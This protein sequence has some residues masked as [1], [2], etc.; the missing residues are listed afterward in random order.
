MRRDRQLSTLRERVEERRGDMPRF[1]TWDRDDADRAAAALA[2]AE[3]TG[4]KHV[5][6]S[7]ELADDALA[8]ANKLKAELATQRKARKAE[9]RAL[10]KR[11]AKLDEGPEADEVNRQLE[12]LESFDDSELET[13]I[14]DY[15]Y[16]ARE[17]KAGAR[18]AGKHGSLAAQTR[19]AMARGDWKAAEKLRDKADSSGVGED[20]IVEYRVYRARQDD[21][22]FAAEFARREAESEAATRANAPWSHG[23]QYWGSERLPEGLRK[24][25]RAASEALNE[26]RAPHYAEVPAYELRTPDPED[27]PVQLKQERRLRRLEEYASRRGALPGRGLLAADVAPTPRPALREQAA[28]RQ[29][30][31]TERE[32]LDVYA[33]PTWT[34]EQKRQAL[35]RMGAH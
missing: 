5:A 34:D 1:A 4:A 17:L 10:E 15:R 24:R 14:D 11:L 18:E 30:E 12:A 33:H 2:A 28:E 19:E 16:H 20:A 3:E 8:R 22:V 13:R 26:L 21:P 29:R 35:E 32:L 25:S 6:L 23:G 9:V 31:Y 7:A 27:Y